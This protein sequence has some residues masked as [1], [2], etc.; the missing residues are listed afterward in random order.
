MRSS[1]RLLEILETLGSVEA[2]TLTQLAHRVDLTAPTVLRL[3]RALEE[4]AWVARL[5]SGA[6]TVG[7]QLL[8]AAGKALQRDPL[9]AAAQIA[10][11]KL[12][13]ELDET[14]SLTV[15]ADI[16]RVCLIE[17]ESSQ[18][19]RFVHGVGTVGPLAAG[20]S[21]KV[22]LAFSEPKL[23]DRVCHG[24][25]EIYTEATPD[26]DDL[27]RQ[28]ADARKQGWAISSGERSRGACAIAV[29]LISPLTRAVYAL[30]VFAPEARA[31]A[32][33]RREWLAALQRTRDDIIHQLV[34]DQTGVSTP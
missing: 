30:T 24:P 27:R 3:L 19:L 10:L 6:Y 34:P 12:R 7:P 29:P 9:I 22:L 5:P 21:G 25:L 32:D 15:A 8:A 28:C 17:L 23:L 33:S 26:A 16:Q 20:A 4:R 1:D 14:V 2:M 13:A 11:E 31:T 18:Q